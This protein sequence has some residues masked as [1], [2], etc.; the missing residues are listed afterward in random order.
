[1]LKL[2]SNKR[3]QKQSGQDWL[4]TAL[5]K[6]LEKGWS[7]S[8]KFLIGL[9]LLAMP[10][11]QATAQWLDRPWDDIPRNMDGSPDLSAPAPR[12]ADGNLDLTGIW[13]G[14]P[15]VANLDPD[16]LLPWA[17]EL[18]VQRQQDFYKERP[19]FNCLPNG[20]ETESAGGWKRFVQ[21]NKTLIILNEDLTYRVI[22]LDGREL[23]EN[24][25]PSF[26]GYSVGYWDG[27]TLVVDSNGYNDQTWVARYG[28]SHTDE[29]VVN[30]RFTRSSFGQ[31]DITVTFTDLGTFTQ[32][33]GYKTSMKLMA[34]TE[35][36]ES[37]CE[38]GTDN[39][40][41]SLSATEGESVFVAPEILEKY[42][43]IYRGI[44]AG[45]E[46]TYEVSVSEGDL[47]ATIIS[48]YDAIGLGAAGLESGVPRKLVPLSETLFDGV[49]LGYRFVVNDNGDVESFIISHV[50]G[51][52]T[53]TRLP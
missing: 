45:G 11:M 38:T 26:T 25:V 3:S 17:S 12:G 32:P 15:P 41:G 53:Y 50:S 40:S 1:M 46:R 22:H 16:I 28:V 27:D 29:L 48:G 36:L 4:F 18:A 51:D 37:V 6:F 13:N 9:F 31:L 47:I 52:Y 39:W 7:L 2:I 14:P 34:D 20:P 35:M 5:S 23:E 33:W 49:G 8:M 30:E 43:G 19:L 44:Y 21:T 42:T 24:P 10:V